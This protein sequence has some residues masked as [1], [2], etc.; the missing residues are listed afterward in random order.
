[1]YRLLSLPFSPYRF[2]F[3]LSNK[4][5]SYLLSSSACWRCRT[6][7]RPGEIWVPCLL[8][9]LSRRVCSVYSYGCHEG[10]HLKCS[11]LRSA[12]SHTEDFRRLL[13]SMT[14]LDQTETINV[15]AAIMDQRGILHNPQGRS[16]CWF[17]YLGY[18]KPGVSSII[19]R[20][21]RATQD[22]NVTT[23]QPSHWSL[24]DS[25]QMECRGYP[26]QFTRAAWPVKC[27]KCVNRRVAYRMQG[28]VSE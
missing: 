10:L 21:D 15:T 8:A 4:R 16:Y 20:T 11:G 5:E 1:M 23:I 27:N 18:F 2:L 12:K 19:P 9:V 26:K 28:K 14:E 25:I 24:V 22:S 17:K 7:P 3:S 6:E 13:C